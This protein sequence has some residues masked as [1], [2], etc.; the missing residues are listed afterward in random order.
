M[1]GVRDHTTPWSVVSLDAGDRVVTETPS[2]FKGLKS[3]KTEEEKIHK[4]DYVSSKRTRKRAK[5]THIRDDACVKT[6]QL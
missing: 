6:A 1:K 5:I 3:N 2:T 4:Q